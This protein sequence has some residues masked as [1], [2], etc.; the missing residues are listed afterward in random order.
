[1]ILLQFS[2][3]CYTL[4]LSSKLGLENHSSSFYPHH[5]RLPNIN[6][7]GYH[8]WMTPKQ[9]KPQFSN[10]GHQFRFKKWPAI[11]CQRGPHPQ[12]VVYK[13]RIYMHCDLLRA[14]IIL[15]VKSEVVSKLRHRRTLGIKEQLTFE[16]HY[17][18]LTEKDCLYLLVLIIINN[19]YF[20]T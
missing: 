4:P 7:G 2:L 19:Q 5:W 13:T 15:K 20:W 16:F 18:Y 10:K 12:Y 11:N 3:F 1:M 9:G 8:L 14:L 6:F 17:L